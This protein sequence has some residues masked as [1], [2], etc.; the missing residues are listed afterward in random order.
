MSYYKE[1]PIRCISC[2][3]LLGCYSDLFE[4]LLEN[5]YTPEDALNELNIFNYCSRI[6]MLNPTLVSFNMENR[7]VI[8]G[9]KDVKNVDIPDPLNF[10]LK[11]AVFTSCIGDKKTLIANKT[12]FIENPKV[13]Q[14]VQVFLLIVYP[15]K[16]I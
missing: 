9:L 12:T 11:P 1:Y 15:Y 3:E 2:N 8:E 6:N 7:E 13:T 5:N 4:E 10:N 14:L 16:M